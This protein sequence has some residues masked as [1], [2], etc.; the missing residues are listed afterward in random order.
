MTVFQQK[1]MIV[2]YFLIIKPLFFFKVFTLSLDKQCIDK[3]TLVQNWQEVENLGDFEVV[4]FEEKWKEMIATFELEDNSW[5][6]ELYEK[7]MKW[8]P[9][10]LRGIFFAGIRTTSQCEA[11]HTHVAKY[12]HS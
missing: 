11:F 8:S 10:H 7:R 2:Q 6:G 1:Y 9:A 12:V 4:T 3:L 5:I